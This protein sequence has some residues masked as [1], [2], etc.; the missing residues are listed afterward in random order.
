MLSAR[1]PI[2]L[3]NKSNSNIFYS[4]DILQAQSKEHAGEED[5]EHDYRYAGLLFPAHFTAA[6]ALR[7]ELRL[8][9]RAD[10]RLV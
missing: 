9:Q 1:Y 6:G 4:D 2:V 5:E 7:Y 3:T 8:A 10:Y